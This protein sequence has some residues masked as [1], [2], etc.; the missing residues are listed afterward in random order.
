MPSLLLS[1]SALC[2]IWN[3][4]TSSLVISSFLYENAAELRSAGLSRRSPCSKAVVANYVI[5]QIRCFRYEN[6]GLTW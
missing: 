3:A 2:H 1:K 4:A 6:S 5:P